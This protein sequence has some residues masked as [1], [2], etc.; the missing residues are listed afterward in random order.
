MPFSASF[1]VRYLHTS[2]ITTI[3]CNPM[4]KINILSSIWSPR[5]NYSTIGSYT[6]RKEAKIYCMKDRW[7]LSME[8]C[9]RI[10]NLLKILKHIIW[11]FS[12]CNCST[13]I[14]FGHSIIPSSLSKELGDI[15]YQKGTM[16]PLKVH[17][18][19]LLDPRWLQEKAEQRA[20]STT[21]E[22]FYIII[23]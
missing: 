21:K 18:A 9:L 5:S 14:M 11:K 15:F 1:N 19:E 20:N 22:K 16:F 13:S 23:L 7:P 6:S 2:H 17:S 12:T 8:S 3:P 4:Q 10:G